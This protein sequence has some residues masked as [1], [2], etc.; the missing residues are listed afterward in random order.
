M[1]DQTFPESIDGWQTVSEPACHAHWSSCDAERDRYRG[2][3]TLFA[4]TVTESET[5]RGIFR[6]EVA[7]LGGLKH[8]HLPQLMGH[9]E[10]N[11]QFYCVFEST[12]A[13]RLSAVLNAGHS[14]D[15][16]LD[17]LWQT[18]SAVQQLHNAG[19][20]HGQLKLDA[21]VVSDQLK[22][23]LSGPCRAVWV[24]TASGLST[25]FPDRI[26]ADLDGLA[27]ILNVTTDMLAA[28]PGAAVREMSEQLRAG[29]MIARDVQ[30]QLGDLLLERSGDGI[31]LIDDRTG[32]YLSR[33]SIV[34]ELF[35][36]ATPPPAAP[37]TPS[38]KIAQS[39][40][41]LIAVIVAAA[42]LLGILAFW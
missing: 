37:Q 19:L 42:A 17:L 11:G 10:L 36:A 30:G 2:R 33:R 12:Q 28:E 7:L 35:E 13:A 15:E 16:L 24:A 32:Q 4:A 29:R 21:V 18:A 41:I 5:F 26:Q 14:T 20:T 25:L 38:P 40:M 9:G 23:C 6:R 8:P 34:D 39:W 27:D 3:L 22:V 31:E 1:V